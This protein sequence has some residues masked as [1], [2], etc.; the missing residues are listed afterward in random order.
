MSAPAL[1]APSTAAAPA[2][3]AGVRALTLAEPLPGF[4]KQRDYVLVQADT[5]GLLFWL[6][7]VA[8]EGPRFLAVP[9]AP[10]FPDYA[11]ALPAAVSTELALPSAAHAELY[12]LVTVLG[13][14]VST[15]TANRRAPVV[16]N[17]LTSRARQVVLADGGH[18][19]RRPL[20]R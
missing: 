17:P 2:A 15:A 16:V 4:P 7:S 3:P 10:F 13:G 9:P 18:P 19:I 20:S 8:A 11:P 1:A 5:D 6:Q 12:C 14:D